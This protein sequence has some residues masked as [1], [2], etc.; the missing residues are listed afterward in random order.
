MM[1]VSTNRDGF[2]TVNELLTSPEEYQFGSPNNWTN[3]LD[4]L[5][6]YAPNPESSILN[7]WPF[8]T[9]NSN[10]TVFQNILEACARNGTE[11]IIDEYIWLGTNPVEEDSDRFN[12]DGVSIDVFS[13]QAVME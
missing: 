5:R 2:L 12:Y 6:C 10:F 11:N 7:E 3:E 13:H 9:E 1:M 8:I 4:G